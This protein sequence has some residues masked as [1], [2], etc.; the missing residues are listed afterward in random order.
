VAARAH[1]WRLVS[2]AEGG[3][4]DGGLLDLGHLDLGHL[5]GLGGGGA[6]GG[7]AHGP[8]AALLLHTGQADEGG[9]L[10]EGAG[11]GDLAVLAGQAVGAG[12]GGN[13]F[14]LILVVVVLLVS[15]WL[16]VQLTSASLRV[17]V[18]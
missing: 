3:E 17:A 16:G 12:E 18:A 2:L 15:V 8:L 6:L 13:L 7:L 1:A 9:E 5:K 4:G 10:G 14:V 11:G